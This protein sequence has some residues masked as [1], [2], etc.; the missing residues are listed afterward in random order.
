MR[1]RCELVLAQ[2]LLEQEGPR[3]SVKHFHKAVGFSVAAADMP[4]VCVSQL[5]L[6]TTLA[7]VSTPDSVLSLMR[8]TERNVFAYGDAQIAADFHAKAA[9]IEA[10]RGSLFVAEKHL[11][12]AETLLKTDPNHWLEGWLCLAASAVYFV[13]ANF[14]AAKTRAERAVACAKRSGHA[15]IEMAATA[16]LGLL[17]L[18][19]GN[20][21]DAGKYLTDVRKRFRG[22]SADLMPLL[23]SC[24]QLQLIRGRLDVCNALIDELDQKI[25]T[26]EPKTVSWYQLAVSPTRIRFQQ[27]SGHWQ[28]ASQMARSAIE[29]A[30]SWSDQSHQISLRV[31]GAD[32]LLELGRTKEAA[33]LIN[34]ADEL[35]N[36]VPLAIFAE[37]ERA[38]AA[39]LATTK[40]HATA[41]AR[42]ERALRLLAAVAGTSARRDAAGSYVRTMEAGDDGPRRP[43]GSTPWNLDPLI[44]TS[45]PGR[46][47]RR[48]EPLDLPTREPGLADLMALVRLVA[49]PQLLAQETFV[50]LREWGGARSLAIVERRKGRAWT[51]TAYAGW[52]AEQAARAA[53]RGDGV[54]RLPMGSTNGRELRLLVVSTPDFR[55]RELVH[56]LKGFVERAHVLEAFEEQERAQTSLW[57]PETSTGRE[58]GV[59]TSAVMTRLLATAKQIAASSLPVLITG[60]T[61]TGKEILARVIHRHSKNAERELVPYNCTGVPKEMVD[62]QLFGHRRGSF[63][64]AQE[65]APGVIRAADGGS[66]L[67]DEIGELD[68][69]VQPKLLRF[70]ESGEVHPLGEARPVK[71]NVRVIAA[72]NADLEQLVRAGR[73][74][75]D[76]FYRLN[77][78]RLRIPALRER[79]EEIPPL[80]HHFLQRYGKEYER[81]R[82]R[83]TDG[84]LKCLLLYEWPG[85]V[86]QLANEVRRIVALAD[87]DAVIG[88]EYLSQQVLAAGLSLAQ[89]VATTADTEEPECRVR[90][91]Q[92]LSGAIEQLER[93]MIHQALEASEGKMNTAARLLGVSRKGLFL[94]RRRLGIDIGF[95]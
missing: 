84:A 48:V 39:L 76:L 94:K 86:R 53:D 88:P 35:A 4:L 82:L 27:S 12:T 11:E 78:V 95:A 54:T 40:G 2:V 91:D 47:S 8:E 71:V 60:Q 75:E 57:P 83:I 58:D 14:E 45:L 5:R 1:A 74:R 70:L 49:H 17:E 10:R 37:V 64:G 89:S 23:D 44:K 29:A 87:D 41:R 16:N 63:T 52:S 50:L 42:F 79:R 61:G 55:C 68:L 66:L 28:T 67:L 30:D 80:V 9:Q 43:L 62:S 77:I 65:H 26:H 38:K 7:G 20:L 46:V 21:D 36:G 25:A 6:L 51:T 15:R 13:A 93:V 85:N 92:P 24:A 3:Q 73:F 33:A 31:L 90:I 72:T 22:F 34:E 32:A 59:Y 56:A 81:P 19:Q 18:H 69:A